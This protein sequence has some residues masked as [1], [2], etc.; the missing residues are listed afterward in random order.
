MN[1]SEDISLALP[2][3]TGTCSSENIPK[4]FAHF[5]VLHVNARDLRARGKLAELSNLACS[6]VADAVCVSET[7][8]SRHDVNLFTIEGYNHCAIVRETKGGG[9]VSLFIRKEF[10]IVRSSCYSTEDEAVQ[11]VRCHIIRRGTACVLVGFYSN[12]RSKFQELLNQI[13]IAVTGVDLPTIL[14]GDSNINTLDHDS[15]STEYLSFLSSRG[16]LPVIAGVT[17]NA[18]STCLDHIFVS[19]G[20][21]LV[22]A[23][24]RIIQ[25]NVISDHFPVWSAFCFESVPQAAHVQPSKTRRR[26]FSSSNFFAFFNALSSADYSSILSTADVNVAC[27]KLERLLFTVYD[28]CF[29]VRAFQCGQQPSS[30]IFSNELKRM[31]RR[32]DRL[33]RKYT[34][35][36][37]D[38]IVKSDYYALLAE[39]RKRRRKAVLNQVE[40]N[41]NNVPPAKAWRFINRLVGKQK[42]VTFP[43][44]IVKD[45]KPIHDQSSIAEL[46]GKYFATMGLQT[47]VGTGLP[48]RQPISSI[49]PPGPRLPPF[50]FEPISRQM[51][52]KAGATIK[53]NL[54]GS[55]SAVPS[56]VLKQ[57]LPI[58]SEPLLYIFNLSLNTGIFPECLKVSEVIP[59]L[60]PKKA[61]ADLTSYRP[62]ALCSFLTKLFEKCVKAQLSEFLNRVSF[63]SKSQHGFMRGRSCDS[64]ICSL[65]D[66]IVHNCEG[67]NGVLCGFLDVA[68]AFDSLSH[69]IFDRILGY[70]DFDTKARLWFRSF[71]SNRR[72]TVRM[73]TAQSLEFDV[74]TGV[75]QGSSLSPLIFAIYI[76]TI[77]EYLSFY[78]NLAGFCY[79]DDLTVGL[80]LNKTETQDSVSVFSSEL[81]RLITVYETLGL[82]LNIQKTEIVLFTNQHSRIIRPPSLL[83]GSSPISLS[84]SASC[85]G[86]TISENL[87]WQ[88]HF[89]NMRQKCYASIAVLSRLRRE[90]LPLAALVTCYKALFVPVITY[91]IL[92]WG[93]AFQAH[94][95]M[96]QVIQRGALRAVFG[97]P[98]HAS[99]VELM[100]KHR[101]LG[102]NQLYIFRV[103]CTV[104]MQLSS[105][106]RPSITP[107]LHRRTPSEYPIRNYHP[108]D[109]VTAFER[110]EYCVRSP[111]C[112]HAKIWNSLPIS[113]RT[114]KTI[115]KFRASVRDHVLA[116]EPPF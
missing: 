97:L 72:I 78:T 73:G 18:S 74:P 89:V 115:H 107:K 55:L 41:V 40:R 14:T 86:L 98:R 77:L 90:G 15:V 38:I 56:Q 88:R 82:S 13:E 100:L 59:L 3:S 30:P 47:D 93:S 49:V 8:F 113:I 50:K 4:P 99:V 11:L 68:K 42:S 25:S 46:F 7:F 94:I 33:L 27:S 65:Y 110:V 69:E 102:L 109:V 31:R 105:E 91:G 66:F 103:A 34:R 108:T 63:F 21:P 9:G 106:A 43:A 16:F 12:N 26:I 111:R 112:Q 29:P 95:R 75:P 104:Y 92:S 114:L 23:T 44:M 2:F 35:N 116:K 85:L 54:R 87:T 80:P 10:T 58:Y 36:K 101:I 79:A 17:R 6:S 64:A 19:I 70:F 76:N 96:L 83:V 62:I 45:G 5:K 20:Q 1:G 52:L 81:Q 32:L 61:A 28:Y 24:S 51:L 37:G 53:V 39:Y 22:E 60:K 48:S 84:P 71:L 57:A 67:G